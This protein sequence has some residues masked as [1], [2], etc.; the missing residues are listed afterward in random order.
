MMLRHCYHF[1][2]G[3]AAPKLNFQRVLYF[4][5]W[6]IRDVFSFVKILLLLRHRLKL[7]RLCEITARLHDNILDASGTQVNIQSFDVVF[8]LTS[9]L[10][11]AA[12]YLAVEIEDIM[13]CFCSG[14][15]VW[16]FHVFLSHHIWLP[17]FA[18]IL[19]T[20]L[21]VSHAALSWWCVQV[22]SVMKSIANFRLFLQSPRKATVDLTVMVKVISAIHHFYSALEDVFSGVLL[23]HIATA[24]L[25]SMSFIGSLL[26]GSEK[27]TVTLIV[28]G[29][30]IVWNVLLLIG[31]PIIFSVKFQEEVKTIITEKAS[32]NTGKI[33]F[34]YR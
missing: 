9:L 18:V 28:S 29:C 10:L 12:A 11:V 13:T 33:C 15:D 17:I 19:G 27:A 25:M 22:H 23:I 6:R 21:I 5:R 24:L 26:D 8:T 32:M 14:L 4:L 16:P 34:M 30:M 2:S 3:L 31:M 20:S 1:F 7:D